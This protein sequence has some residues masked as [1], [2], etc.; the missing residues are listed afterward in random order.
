MHRDRRPASLLQHLAVRS[1]AWR[2][3]YSCN[4]I[5]GDPDFEKLVLRISIEE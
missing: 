3:R 1:S 4:D 5:G 2:R